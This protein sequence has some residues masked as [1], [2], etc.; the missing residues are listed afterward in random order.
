M[1]GWVP[2]PALNP[3]LSSLGIDRVASGRWAGSFRCRVCGGSWVPRL[4]PET[5]ELP[6]DYWVCPSECN[7]EIY[8]GLRE[9]WNEA[10]LDA[11]K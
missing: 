4:D 6:P 3:P 11:P 10:G 5:G 8:D 9:K 2:P 1:A 7:E